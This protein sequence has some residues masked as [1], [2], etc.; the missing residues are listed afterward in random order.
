MATVAEMLD[1]VARECR[2]P[3]PNNWVS[4]LTTTSMDLKD[5]LSDTIDELLERIDRRGVAVARADDGAA[6]GDGVGAGGAGRSQ[7]E[8]GAAHVEAGL[9]AVGDGDRTGVGQIAEVATGAAGDVGQQADGGCREALT[10]GLLPQGIEI[11]L[12]DV[13]QDQVLRL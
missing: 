10:A 3:V 11:A 8:A 5:Y 13:G 2:A 12:F 4:S 1:K 7:R 6:R 9:D